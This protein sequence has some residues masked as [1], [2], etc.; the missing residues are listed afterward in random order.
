MAIREILE[1][2]DPILREKSERVIE[3]TEEISQLIKDLEDTL[4]STETGIGLAAPQIGINKRIIAW[5]YGV[6]AEPVRIIINPILKDRRDKYIDVESCLSVPGVEEKVERAYELWV[7]GMTKSGKRL[8]F[9]FK[10]LMA[11][12]VQHEVDHLNGILFID[13]K[14]G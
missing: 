4:D 7:S 1:Y 14:I 3:I 11:R 5:R 6:D 2:P 9:K 12:M 8:S 10:G 13:K